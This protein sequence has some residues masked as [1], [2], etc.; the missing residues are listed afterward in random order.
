MY[1][2]NLLLLLTEEKWPIDIS[3]RTMFTLKNLFRPEHVVYD[4]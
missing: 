2:T 1:L 3:K 4:S